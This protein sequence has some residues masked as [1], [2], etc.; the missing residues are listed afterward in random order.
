MRG[1]GEG[2]GVYLE[3]TCCVGLT[4]VQRGRLKAVAEE[5]A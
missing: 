3:E 1:T 5:G 2:V 4:G